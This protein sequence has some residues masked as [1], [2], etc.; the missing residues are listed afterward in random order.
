MEQSSA[1]L[2]DLDGTILD[3][4]DDL[5]LAL[6]HV[7]KQSGLPEVSPA[8]YKP[9]ASHG[10]RG[11]LN[12]GFGDALGKFDLEALKAEFLAFY[13]NNIC[14]Q[15][16][17][18]PFAQET[19]IQLNQRD[20]PWGIVTNKPEFLTTRLVTYFP[21]LEE[22]R[23]I[24]SGDTLPKA[25]P[26]PGLINWAMGRINVLPQNTLYIGDAERDI[27]A[28]RHAFTKTAVVLNG[29]IRDEDKPLNWGADLVLNDLSTL[30]DHLKKIV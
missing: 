25:K 23:V 14:V 18:M 8:E 28:G 24:V 30:T 27:E 7:L 26:D 9:V 6:N 2:F 1:V 5:G 19:L 22:C 16:S 17:Y 11:L 13:L 10:S 12:L 21:L 4:A 29:Y 3:T 15:T 20:I